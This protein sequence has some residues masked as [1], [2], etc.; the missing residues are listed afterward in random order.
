M[1]F[2]VASYSFH[3]EL[4]SGRQDMFKY[5]TDCKEYFAVL[6]AVRHVSLFLCSDNISELIIV[7]SLPAAQAG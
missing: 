5:I 1:K 7:A 2:S 4:E 6:T 3:R